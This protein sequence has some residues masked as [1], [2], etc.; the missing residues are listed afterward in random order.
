M[1]VSLPK[2]QMMVGERRGWA[3]LMRILSVMSRL[4]ELRAARGANPLRSA[5]T[6]FARVT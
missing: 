1:Y 2:R 4:E 5:A 3:V 6:D